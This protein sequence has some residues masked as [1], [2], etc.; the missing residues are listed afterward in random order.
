MC[1]ALLDQGVP[2]VHLYTL[3]LEAS[4]LAILEN[5]GLVNKAQ[6]RPRRPPAPCFCMSRGG[7]RG[8]AGGRWPAQRMRHGPTCK[9]CAGGSRCAWQSC[10]EVVGDSRVGSMLISRGV[11]NAGPARERRLTPLGAARAAPAHAAVAQG[12]VQQARR[13]GRAAHPLVQPAQVVPHAHRRLGLLPDR[14][15]R[16]ALR[17]PELDSCPVRSTPVSAAAAGSARLVRGSCGLCERAGGCG[18]ACP[19]ARH[20]TRS[21]ESCACSHTNFLEGGHG[22]HW[23]RRAPAADG[24]MCNNVNL[25]FSPHLGILPLETLNVWTRA[26]R[27]GNA[28]SPAYGTLSDYQFMRRHSSNEKRRERARAAWGAS[29]GS[30]G[31]VVNVFVKYTSGARSP[32]PRPAVCST[33][34]FAG[35]CTR[36]AAATPFVALGT[37]TH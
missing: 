25:G 3:N 2:G 14:R 17:C 26:G 5:L 18:S 24:A 7:W 34:A 27:W 29:L 31:D 37:L 35:R 33:L 1:R 12:A 8:R 28:R 32:A 11:A 20:P 23:G 36:A 16:A 9:P 22:A 19:S 15:A 6:A 30:V 21:G 13:G 10:G 4:A